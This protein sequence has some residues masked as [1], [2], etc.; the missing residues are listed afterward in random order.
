MVTEL[1]FLVDLGLLLLAATVFNYL[2]KL[3]DQPPLL[4]Y[5]LAGIAVGPIGLGSLGLS[6]N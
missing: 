3:F 2:A 6:F 5:I 4:A 1:V